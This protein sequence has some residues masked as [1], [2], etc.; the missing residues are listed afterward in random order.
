MNKLLQIIKENDE[1]EIRYLEKGTVGHSSAI[2]HL[3]KSRIKEMEALVEELRKK[4][5]Q[6][7]AYD[8]ISDIYDTIEKLKI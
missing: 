4:G 6:A 2:S 3:K 1:A 7:L 8:I 5:R